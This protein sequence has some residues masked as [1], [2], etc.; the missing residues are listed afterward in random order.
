MPVWRY[1]KHL[2]NQNNIKI[3]IFEITFLKKADD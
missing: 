3:K 2:I 1:L